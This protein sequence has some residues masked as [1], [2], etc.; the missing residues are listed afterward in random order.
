MCPVLSHM[1]PVLSVR[2]VN[3]LRHSFSHHD[4]VYYPVCVP[5]GKLIIGDFKFG[6]SGANSPNRQIKN[7]AKVSRHTVF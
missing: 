7:L 1:F 4:I 2:V 6:D 5:G 3:L